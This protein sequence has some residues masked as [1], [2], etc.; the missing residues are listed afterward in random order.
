MQDYNYVWA[1]CLE[2]TLEVSCCKFPPA[3][4]LPALWAAN[5]EALLAFI[6]QVHLGQYL[7]VPLD[8]T[9]IHTG[10]SPLLSVS[11]GV[12]GQVFDGSGVPVQNAMV[13]VK[14]RK[15]MSPFR[16]DKHGEYYRLLLPG[17]YSFTV[18]RPGYF[19]SDGVCWRA[20]PTFALWSPGG[21]PG[22]SDSDRDRQ[23][24]ARS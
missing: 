9:G 16:S 13:E 1:Q 12:K 22:S 5:R 10:P 4:Q 17:N 7:S 11:A 8:P 2:L 15:N 14:G 18:N 6:K 20:D 23:R 19:L 3:H 21:V 24:P